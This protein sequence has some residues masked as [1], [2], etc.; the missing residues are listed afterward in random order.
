M[1]SIK[2]DFIEA[3]INELGAELQSL[4]KINGENV[5]WKKNEF[6]WNRYAPLLFPIVG[7][8][9][10]DSYHH[11]GE[12]Y[13]MKQHGFARDCTFDVVSCAAE[14]VTFRLI[15][16]EFTLK[17]YPFSFEL[18]QCFE[19]VDTTLN[20]TSKVKNTG[21]EI[22]YYNLGGHP[23][24]HIVGNLG[25]YSL[26]FGGNFHT[27]HHLIEGNYYSNESKPI[28][29]T[30]SFEL[31][32]SFFEKDA[33]VIKDVPFDKVS[34]VHQEKGKLVSMQC[35]DW[36]AI[37]FWTK[38]GA[39]FF[40][41]EPWWG[42]ADHLNSSGILNEKPGILSLNSNDTRTHQYSIMLH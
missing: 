21:D 34:L 19:I 35:K 40:C 9:I 7:R 22:L 15:A 33:L 42:W 26:D 25:E 36:S 27:M 4:K 24:F 30:N 3:S 23:G 12:N 1:I 2:N 37:G 29:L 32:D 16:N 8:L 38:I 39:P 5:I 13:F 31:Q 17:Q 18:L 14:K 10:N 41:I 28:K 20:I 6:Y 11:K